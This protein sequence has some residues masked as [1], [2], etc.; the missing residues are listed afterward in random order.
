[1]KSESRRTSTLRSSGIA[2]TVFVT[3]VA[4]CIMGATPASASGTGSVRAWGNN[5]YGELGN[6]KSVTSKDA[7]AEVRGLHGVEAIAAGGSHGVALLR[8]GTVMAWGDNGTGQLGNGTN[9]NENTPVPV[10]GLSGVS[11]ISAGGTF[12]LALLSDGTVMAWGDNSEGEL[13]DDSDVSYSNTPVQVTGLIGVTAIS[14]GVNHAIA[15]L[16]DGTVMTWGDNTFGELG[17][18]T[19]GSFSNAPVT[20]NSL[21]GA[22]AVAA[23]NGFSE[24]LVSGGEVVAWG[25][26]ASGQ[27]GDGS[28]SGSDSPVPVVGLSSI[29]S[30]AAGGAFSLAVDNA[31]GVV[32]W[33][34]NFYGELGN[35]T[36]ANSDSP[37][38]VSGLSGVTAIAAGGGHA[39]ATLDTGVVMAWGDNF[40]GELATRSANTDVVVP[41]A[42]RISVLVTDVSASDPGSNRGFSMA[43]AKNHTV[44]TWGY[45]AFG[46]LGNGTV[47]ANAEKPV[48]VKTLAGVKTVSA[49]SDFS[50]ALMGNGTVMAWG[51]NTVG[52]LGNGSTGNDITVPKAITGLAGVTAIAA[53][54]AHGLALLTNGTVMAWGDNRYGELGDGSTASSASPVMVTGLNDVTAIAAGGDFSLALLSDGSVMAWGDNS[55]GELGDGTTATSDVPVPVSG[56]NGV[57]AVAAG[58][59]HGLALINGGSVMA[60]GNNN[61]GQLGSG[62]AG[63]VGDTPV[64]VAGLTGSNVTAVAAGLDHSLG[65]LSNGTVV[66]WGD[67]GSGELGNASTTESDTP[68]P[69]SNLTNVISISAGSSFSL[70][71]NSKNRRVYSWG[72]DAGTE[73]DTPVVVPRIAGIGSISAGGDFSLA[74]RGKAPSPSNVEQRLTVGRAFGSRRQDHRGGSI[75]LGAGNIPQL[76]ER[77]SPWR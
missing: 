77:H 68:V 52:Q 53:G 23:G 2:I 30:I 47:H 11:A 14:A 5:T 38:P 1:M 17:D 12:S 33:G 16:S 36:N 54:F 24:A 57:T 43:L 6:G 55:Y 34:D 31:G 9:S 49:G 25:N 74:V 51:D 21:S 3:V 76:G 39:L 7:P 27:L 59:E 50:L 22:T 73:S 37:S 20:V 41:V 45:D 64:A 62:N 63:G 32:A 44:K 61:V 8:S 19:S 46:E 42:V 40:Y 15:L 26:N 71:L 70:A 69:V 56:L 35:G 48:D 60:W 29:T 75:R 10:T 67:N 28:T 4:Y 72:L 65:L 13:G 18:G 58:L 66:A